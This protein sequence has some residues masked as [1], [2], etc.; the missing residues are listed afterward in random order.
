M[1][2]RRLTQ[3]YL[4]SVLPVTQTYDEILKTKLVCGKFPL[5]VAGLI[6][7]LGMT[8]LLAAVSLFLAWPRCANTSNW[9]PVFLPVAAGL[10]I[11]VQL[12]FYMIFSFGVTVSKPLFWIKCDV[13][14][15][16]LLSFITM[17]ASWMSYFDCI[18]TLVNRIHTIL[19]FTGSLIIIIS[20]GAILLMYRHKKEVVLKPRERPVGDAN[21]AVA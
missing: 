4:N 8:V 10:S 19:C 15:N 17:V 1:D 21:V 6:K 13:C 12:F 7:S 9:Y 11:L 3:R 16:L 2:L 20:C 5:T 18:A 14:S